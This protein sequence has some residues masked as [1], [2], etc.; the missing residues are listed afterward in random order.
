MAVHLPPPESPSWP[1]Y[2]SGKDP[3]GLRVR[4]DPGMGMCQVC[5]H[6]HQHRTW[7]NLASRVPQNLRPSSHNDQV[8]G[9]PTPRWS[10]LPRRLRAQ[11]VCV[12]ETRCPI[13]SPGS[14][15]LSPLNQG[16]KLFPSAHHPGRGRPLLSENSDCSPAASL[17]TEQGAGPALVQKWNLPGESSARAARLICG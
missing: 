8:S 15:A 16:G 3:A 7:P 13:P 6:P 5:S 2:S 17:T 12:L 10:L 4:P 14:S 1:P 11:D 9:G